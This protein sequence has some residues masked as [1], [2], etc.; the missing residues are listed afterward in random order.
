MDKLLTKL[1]ELITYER[2]Y[3]YFVGSFISVFLIF[4]IGELITSKVKIFLFGII[5][6]F[7]IGIGLEIYKFT[8]KPSEETTHGKIL[9]NAIFI[10]LPLVINYIFY[11]VV[12]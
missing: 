9:C 12:R 1:R 10:T 2:L 11:I 6:I 7:I 4:I 8:T 3:N 5:S